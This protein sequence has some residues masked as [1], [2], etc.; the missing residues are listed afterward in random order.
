MLYQI[1]MVSRD[2]TGANA[3]QGSEHKGEE[4]IPSFIICLEK[5]AV[6][7]CPLCICCLALPF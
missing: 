5:V 2:A 4:A 6:Q 7:Q 1:L 3:M